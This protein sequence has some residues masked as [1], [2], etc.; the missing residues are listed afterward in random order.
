[1]RGD[2]F[3]CDPSPIPARDA[4]KKSKS[5]LKMRRKKAHGTLSLNV[6]IVVTKIPLGSKKMNPLKLWPTAPSKTITESY[7]KPTNHPGSLRGTFLHKNG[8]PGAS[9]T[10]NLLLRTELL[11]PLSYQATYLYS[12]IYRRTNKPRSAMP[13]AKVKIP[14]IA[15]KGAISFISRPFIAVSEFGAFFINKVN[16]LSTSPRISPKK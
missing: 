7:T 5:L 13:P 2:P 10:H 1:M 11:Y 4:G 12:S 6:S 16:P 14:I 9:R 15:K 8:D 3:K